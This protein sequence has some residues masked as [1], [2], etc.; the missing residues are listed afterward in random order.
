MNSSCLVHARTPLTHPNIPPQELADDG[1]EDRYE[2][3]YKD[4]GY[5]DEYENQG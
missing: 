3:Q 2:N 4:D 1:C 5:E